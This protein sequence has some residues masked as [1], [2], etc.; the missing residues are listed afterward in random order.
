MIDLLL[1]APLPTF[2]KVSDDE[3]TNSIDIN[4]F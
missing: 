3:L 2:D 1:N 4:L